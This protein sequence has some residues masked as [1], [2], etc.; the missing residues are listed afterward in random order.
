[1]VAERPGSDVLANARIIKIMQPS[2]Q[3]KEQESIRTKQAFPSKF[4]PESAIILKQQSP[5]AVKS[6]P[7]QINK[8]IPDV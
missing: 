8:L 7:A 4:S 1:L 2:S 3:S 6:S 5:E